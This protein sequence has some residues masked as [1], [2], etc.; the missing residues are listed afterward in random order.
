MIGSQL[1]AVHAF[2]SFTVVMV[3]SIKKTQA[4][5]VPTCHE[6]GFRKTQLIHP[7]QHL[8]QSAGAA[9]YTDCISA[10]E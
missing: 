9:E 2:D 3:C 8:A 10:K 7:Y 5:I 6:I 4:L 1:I